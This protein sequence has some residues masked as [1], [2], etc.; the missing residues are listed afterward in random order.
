MTTN[1]H[2]GK[3]ILAAAG[4]GDPELITVRAARYFTK[5]RCSVDRSIGE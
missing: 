4:P 2:I 3:V 5:S 1:L